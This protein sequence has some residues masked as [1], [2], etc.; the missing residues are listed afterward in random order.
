MPEEL[1][2]HLQVAQLGTNRCYPCGQRHGGKYY[3]NSFDSSDKIWWARCV[4][5][6]IWNFARNRNYVIHM[7]LAS[8]SH[9]CVEDGQWYLHFC[10]WQKGVCRSL[11]G[12]NTSHSPEF[13]ASIFESHKPR[14][15]IDCYWWRFSINRFNSSKVAEEAEESKSMYNRWTI[16]GGWNVEACIWKVSAQ[17]YGK[18]EWTTNSSYAGYSRAWRENFGSHWFAD[19]QQYN[20]RKY[21]IRIKN[22]KCSSHT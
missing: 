4:R 3:H 18:R 10:K 6:M 1:T 9:I 15:F 5:R 16:V 11:Y 21:I 14:S 2:K 8:I 19:L 20:V 7:V 22:G 12:W 17:E 13:T